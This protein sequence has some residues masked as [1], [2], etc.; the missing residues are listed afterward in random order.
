MF[1]DKGPWTQFADRYISENIVLF[2]YINDFVVKG[3]N[4]VVNREIYY[5]GT[6]FLIKNSVLELWFLSLVLNMSKTA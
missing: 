4:S 3:F 6:I 1:L 5:L 2:S